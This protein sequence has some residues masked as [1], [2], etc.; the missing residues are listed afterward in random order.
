MNSI[1]NTVLEN[2][3]AIP[4]KNTEAPLWNSGHAPSTGKPLKALKNTSG[5]KNEL[6]ISRTFHSLGFPLLVSPQLLRTRS[7]GQVDLARITKD[8]HGWLLEIGEVKS[9]TIGEELF[10]RH[11]KLRLTASQKFLSGL[12]GHRSRLT[13]LLR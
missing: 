13:S 11:Q 4:Q 8:Q 2:I 3:T 5:L 1:P 7:L 12:F 10:Q 6:F 9:S